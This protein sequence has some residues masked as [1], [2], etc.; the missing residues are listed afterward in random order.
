[1]SDTPATPAR[2]VSLF[3]LVFLFAVFGAFLL[4]IRYFYHPASDPAFVATPENLSKDLAWRA[5]R[6]SRRKTLQEL[7]EEQKKRASTYAWIDQRAGIVQLPIERAMELTA[8]ELAAKQ[9]AKP[10][11]DE[12]RRGAPVAK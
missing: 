5:D 12:S 8:R 10:L 9:P 2:P 11:R 7:E 4:V 6:D 1:M 3:T